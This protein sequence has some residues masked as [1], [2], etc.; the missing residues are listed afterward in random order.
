MDLEEQKNKIMKMV[1]VGMILWMIGFLM[2]LAGI[3]LEFTVYKPTLQGLSGKS[4]TG[5]G[6]C[7]AWCTH[8]QSPASSVRTYGFNP[9][10][11]LLL[12]PSDDF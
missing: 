2:V 10:Y 9:L 7:K 11:F 3:A 12:D 1:K 6:N 4:K 5:M 8:Q